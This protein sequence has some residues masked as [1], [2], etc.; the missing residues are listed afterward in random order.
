MKVAVLL[1]K[2]ILA[3][4]GTTAAVSATDPGIHGSGKTNLIISNK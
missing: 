2:N 1:A 4:L 3:S